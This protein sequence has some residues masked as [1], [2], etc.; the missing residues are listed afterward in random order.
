MRRFKKGIA[1]ASGV[2][3]LLFQSKQ[4]RQ[5]RKS[6]KEG[7]RE[8]AKILQLLNAKDYIVLND[9]MLLHRNGVSS[10]SDHVILSIFGVFVIETKNYGGTVYGEA[11]NKNWTVDYE[12][13]KFTLYNPIKQNEGHAKAIRNTLGDS[14]NIIPLVAFSDRCDLSNLGSAVT[15]VINYEN[16]LREIKLHKRVCYSHK[17]VKELAN[18]LKTKRIRGF[19]PRILH[20]HKVRGSKWF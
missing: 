17:Q 11:D 15:G 20:T 9:V 12:T 18:R 3:S 8:V 2:L 14:I 10:Q 16:L 13:R 6:G 5:S 19:I 7:E 4:K 1:V